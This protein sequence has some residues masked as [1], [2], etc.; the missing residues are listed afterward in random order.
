MVGRV[1]FPRLFRSFR[2]S[3]TLLL[4]V[5]LSEAFVVYKPFWSKKELECMKISQNNSRIGHLFIGVL[6][7][8][9][10]E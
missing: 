7:V 1:V 9:R 5:V 6:V 10:N 2:S 4:T 8:M 3:F